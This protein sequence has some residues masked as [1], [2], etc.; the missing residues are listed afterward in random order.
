VNRYSPYSHIKTPS[1]PRVQRYRKSHKVPNAIA[2]LPS[3]LSVLT[4]RVNATV[5]SWIVTENNSKLIRYTRS[6]RVARLLP[7]A[8][9]AS[10]Q[11]KGQSLLPSLTA[12][13]VHSQCQGRKLPRQSSFTPRHNVNSNGAIRDTTLA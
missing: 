4:S 9:V 6:D 10:S 5:K 7:N 13:A 1:L 2:C 12:F 8:K 11:G 3:P